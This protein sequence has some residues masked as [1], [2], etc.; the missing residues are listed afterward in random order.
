MTMKFIKY[1]Y[2][3]ALFRGDYYEI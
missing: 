2:R 3:S 1:Q